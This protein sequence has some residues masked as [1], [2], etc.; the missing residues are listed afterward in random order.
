[1]SPKK[2][3]IILHLLFWIVAWSFLSWFFTRLTK[4]YQY[5]FL[6]TGLLLVVAV[7]T[8]YFFNYYLIPRFLL[9]KRYVLFALLTLFTG[10]VSLWL[11]MLGILTIFLHLITR[12]SSTGKGLPFMIDPVFLIAGLYCVILAGVAIRL[13]RLAFRLQS[14]QM[15]LKN[16]NLDVENKLKEYK[17]NALKAQ[18]QPHFLFNTLNNLYWLTLNKSE[19]APGLVLKLSDLLDYSLYRTKENRVPLT[20][21]IQF[22]HNYL[23]IIKIRFQDASRIRFGILGDPGNRMVAPLVF[24]TFLENA[25]K[26]GLSQ[27]ISDAW[28]KILLEIN[29]SSIIFSITNNY[30]PSENLSKTESG[31]GLAQVKS[32]LDLLYPGLH[33][34]NITQN[35]NEFHVN[36]V[37]HE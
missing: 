1:M 8:T 13:I 4:E 12:F 33:T 25:C 28:I 36:L 30:L 34:L 29:E 23:D 17:L 3:R 26:H 22:L 20:N 27:L 14:D 32:R 11:E 7:G 6:F 9:T 5:T 18:F 10:L 24:I 21:E 35:N 31:I 15:T 37:I 16:R 2:L 19:E